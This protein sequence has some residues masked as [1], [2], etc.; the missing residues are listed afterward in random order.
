MRSTLTAPGRGKWV[1]MPAVAGQSPERALRSGASG[2]AGDDV[3][4]EVLVVDHRREADLAVILR[5]TGV[6]W[7][8]EVLV[9]A[10]PVTDRETAAG[11]GETDVPCSNKDHRHLGPA[12]KLAEELGCGPNGRRG[13]TIAQPANANPETIDPDGCVKVEQFLSRG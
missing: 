5:A 3:A 10:D 7:K 6:W 13:R 4:Q 9:P 11:K 8:R 2:A 1:V 12:A